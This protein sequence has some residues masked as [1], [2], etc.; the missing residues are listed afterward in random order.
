VRTPITRTRLIAA[1]VLLVWAPCVATAQQPFAT[2]DA[3][4]TP[5]ASTHVEVFD[6]YDW[7]QP[8]Q[9]PHRRQNTFNMRVNFGLGH[10]LELDLD[11]PLLAIAN[12]PSTVPVTPIGLGDTNFGVKYNFRDERPDSSAPALSTALYIETPTGNAA[13]GLG[14]GLIDVWAY[15]VAQKSLNSRVTLR[16]NGGYLFAGN[17]STGVLGIETTR[18]HIV[19]GSASLVEAVSKRWALGA[20][21]VGA[22]SNNPGLDREQVQ[23]LVGS[24]Y[25]LRE[26]FSLSLAVTS[27][28]FPA[29][30]RVG[31]LVGF[32]MDFPRT[33]Q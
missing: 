28:W 24:S 33:K 6:E 3:A 10:G 2:D 9:L 13:T 15:L 16:L 21:L 27:G 30:P 23:Y 1:A 25:E 18:G 17:T 22:V 31:M 26:G 19:T 32:A 8:S 12:T 11:S 4:V 14:S 20:E 7:L 5:K 29:S